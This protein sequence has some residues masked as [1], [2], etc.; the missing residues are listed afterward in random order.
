[1]EIQPEK[2]TRQHVLD[3][4]KMI[5]KEQIALRPS[6]GYDV[7]INEKSY[8][9]KDVMRLAHELATGVYG[10][11]A[12]GG[13][14]T[15]KYFSNLGFEIKPKSHNELADKSHV[16]VWKLGCNWGKGKPSFYEF[17]RDNE[18]LIGEVAFPYQ[19]NDLV[20]VTEGYHVLAI[21][22]VL[23]KPAPVTGASEFEEDF[24][25][26]QIEYVETVTYGEAEYHVL[27][28]E[29]RFEYKLQ[30]GIRQVQ[31][32][33]IRDKAIELWNNR[34][35]YQNNVIPIKP[36]KSMNTNPLN[37]ILYG[38]PGAGKTYSTIDR[39]VA[40]VDGQRAGN[41]TDNKKRFDQ[42]RADGQI[43]FITFH[44]N[45]SYEDFVTG[46]RPEP[47]AHTLKFERVPGIF[48]E[49][50][51]RAR[52]N[53]ERSKVSSTHTPVVVDPPFD[54]VFYSFFQ[55][56]IEEEV[57][58][59]EI[60]MRSKS[61][62]IT[63]IDSEDQHIKFTKSSGG[64]GHDLVISIVK[65]IYDGSRTYR[66]D[67]LGIYYFPLVDAL[68]EHSKQLEKPVPTEALQN[69]VLIIDEINRANISRVFGELITL[70]EDDKRLG[71]E[72]ELRVTLPGGIHDF[73]V[74]PN[75]Y[76]I[77]TMNTA[78]KSIALVDIALRRR[79]EFVG[80]YPTPE[81]I[82]ELVDKGYISPSGQL[83]LQTLNK[84]IFEKKKTADFLIGH[85]YLIG[86]MQDAQIEDV[87]RKKIV[88]L[89]LE[90]FSGRHQEVSDL[91]NNSGWKVRYNEARFEW[92]IAQS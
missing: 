50:A 42:L 70:L 67:G 43:E 35:S 90:Y 80:M 79:F 66:Q 92:D 87:I 75:L 88:P 52:E 23:T 5:E 15:N 36:Q 27:P 84:G 69:Y 48:M 78:D 26:L 85:A 60:K 9:P 33:E 7:I 62:S 82:K 3:A 47:D 24:K 4:V 11:K 31:Q 89:L 45:Y 71:E 28:T 18:I 81:V 29:L 32:K 59:V 51:T 72:N 30:K 64:T 38:P 86:K 49:I 14:A 2:I 34:F 44:Q 22:R 1:M 46:L 57:P 73:G 54:D 91:F 63:K 10:W 74:P 56:L 39:A 12:G 41:H 6:T 83:L 61:F 76:L 13:E 20:L 40:I 77:G 68:K 55:K 37:T 65:G 58:G 53:W 8:P 17:I 16:T 19:V 25:R 21:A